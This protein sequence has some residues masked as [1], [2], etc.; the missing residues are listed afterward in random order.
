VFTVI[1]RPGLYGATDVGTA[2][3]GRSATFLG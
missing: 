3:G 2:L 1:G